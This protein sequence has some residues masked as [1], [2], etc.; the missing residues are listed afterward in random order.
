MIDLEAARAA[1]G[2]MGPLTASVEVPSLAYQDTMTLTRAMF[3]AGWEGAEWLISQFANEVSDSARTISYNALGAPPRMRE[4]LDEIQGAVLN[5]LGPYAQEVR[6]WEATLEIP[7]SDFKADKLGQYGMKLRQMGA[8]AK[9]HPDTLLLTLMAAAGSTKCYDGQYLCDTDHSEF[10]SGTQSNDLTTGYDDDEIADMLLA[11]DANV[12]AMQK[13]TDDRGEPL[14]IGWESGAVY[15]ILC[16]PEARATFNS[17]ASANEISGTSNGWK[18]RL[19]VHSSARFTTA[20]QFWFCYLGG[21]VKPFI[22]QYQTGGEPSALKELGPGSAHCKQTGRI[23]VS[24]QGHY[25]VL[26]GDW[27]YIIENNKS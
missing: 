24:T 25:T 11:L 17:L 15:D 9:R 20:D 23:W 22:V 4:W 27:R 10:D 18:G 1:V 6:D 26:P 21:P 19:R 5:N 13:F 7:L 14:D 8:Y 16:R 3:L 2:R 12:A